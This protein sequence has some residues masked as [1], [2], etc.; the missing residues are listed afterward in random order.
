[1]ILEDGS[2]YH[3]EY[4]SFVWAPSPT[5]LILF[6][7]LDDAWL[8]PGSDWPYPNRAV[9]N[10]YGALKPYKPMKMST[11]DRISGLIKLQ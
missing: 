5:G 3:S 11:L 7:F 8:F 4:E 9:F 6:P 10:T 2:I 1:M